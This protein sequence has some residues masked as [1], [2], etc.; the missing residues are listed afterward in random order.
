MLAVRTLA[1]LAVPGGQRSKLRRLRLWWSGGWRRAGGSPLTPRPGAA[2]AGRGHGLAALFA[3]LAVFGGFFFHAGPPHLQGGLGESAACGLTFS[4]PP[5]LRSP[6]VGPRPRQRRIGG[7]QLALITGG[8]A[9]N[10]AGLRLAL[11]LP[12]RGGRDLG[13]A[14]LPPCATAATGAL[15]HGRLVQPAG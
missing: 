4:P 3:V 12:L 14:R 1:H 9:A 5:G 7:S 2:A 10:A 6:R 11:A 8:F 15:G 13:G